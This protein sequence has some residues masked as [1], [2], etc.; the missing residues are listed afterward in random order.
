M[1]NRVTKLWWTG[2]AL[3]ALL[4]SGIAHAQ[5]DPMP[6]APSVM[7]PATDGGA[8]AM[9]PVRQRA[10]IGMDSLW[11]EALRIHYNAI[12]MDGHIDTPTLMLDKDYDLGIRH[13]S[14]TAHVD[15]PRM[16]DGGLDAPFFSI[17]VSAR[18]GE[19]ERATQRARSMIAEVKRQVALYPDR[20]DMAY[21]ADDVRRITQTGR[22]AILMGL[23]GGHAL[24]GSEAVLSELYDAGIR[25]VT[26]THVNTNSWADASQTPPR[27]NGLNAKGE[28]MIRAMNRLG[29]L[30]DLSHTADATFY[31][32]LA[33]SEAPVILSHSSARGATGVVR[34]I[35]DAMLR[36]LAANGGVIMINFYE[37]MINRHLTPEAIAEAER[38]LGGPGKDWRRYWRVIYSIRQAQGIPPGTR[39]DI[40]DHIDHAA[41]VAGI[42][43]V[44]LG[45]DFDGARMPRD[46][47]D[48]TRLPW[49]TYGLLQR[50]YSEADIYKIL[51][52]NTLRVME[53]AQQVGEQLRGGQ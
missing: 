50:G 52:G 29:M 51:G 10:L 43:H 18:Y 37:P 4:A 24:A 12:V 19:G 32:A 3:L 45:S 17:Y 13:N 8:I 48:V 11:A 33:I 30:V 15:L 25:Y 41:R 26:L 21:T 9:N 35:D 39:K 44:A 22:K 2:F 42:D 6:R 31:D 20:V 40:L 7:P 38:R 53:A 47:E 23:E 46:M 14:R 1:V 49:L 34:N 16:L 27:W 36:A 28:A 5:P